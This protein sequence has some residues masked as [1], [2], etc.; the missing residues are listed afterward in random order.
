MGPKNAFNITNRDHKL[1]EPG[2][3]LHERRTKKRRTF[4][5]NQE[6]GVNP[7]PAQAE[8]TVSRGSRAYRAPLRVLLGARVLGASLDN[9]LAEGCAPET[10]RLLATRSQLIVSPTMRRA[11]ADNWLDLLAPAHEPAGF[12]N[13]RVPLVFDRIIAAQPQIRELADALLAPMPTSRGVAM[14]RSLL[15]DG[16]GP[17]YNSACSTDLELALSEVI[18]RLDPL[19]A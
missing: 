1:E 6:L 14:A 19:A 11:L 3:G 10:S 7:A 17:I 2:V 18:A 4:N 9:K 12:L 15:S 5:Q 13:S 8:A 16:S